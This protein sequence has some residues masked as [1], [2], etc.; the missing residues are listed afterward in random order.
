MEVVRKLFWRKFCNSKL[1]GTFVIH[2]AMKKTELLSIKGD[3][4]ILKCIQ[5]GKRLYTS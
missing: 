4:Q 1:N 2:V 5:V 3:F